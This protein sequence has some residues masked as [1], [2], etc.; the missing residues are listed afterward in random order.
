MV[1]LN[2][3]LCKVFLNR[4]VCMCVLLLVRACIELE[5]AGRMVPLKFYDKFLVVQA[6]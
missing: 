4:Y 6:I 1:L 3:P 5:H 2:S